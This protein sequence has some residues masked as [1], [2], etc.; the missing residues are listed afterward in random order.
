M[1]AKRINLKLNFFKATSICKNQLHKIVMA[2][3]KFTNE[4]N[5]SIQNLNKSRTIC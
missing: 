2:L 5:Y 1:S 4:A 3:Q